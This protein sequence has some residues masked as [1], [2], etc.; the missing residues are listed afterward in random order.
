[1]GW[2]RFNRGTNVFEVSDDNG[3][4]WQ[5]LVIAAGGL[6]LGG[7]LAYTDRLNTFTAGQDFISDSGTNYDGANIELRSATPRISFHV[8][9]VIASQLG[10]ETDGSI[11]ARD[12]QAQD[13]RH[14]KRLLLQRRL[15]SGW[16]ISLRME[17]TYILVVLM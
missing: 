17:V 14:L 6:A 4:S 5:T 7:N 1:M 11:V 8:P 10:V 3:A 15:A 13:M 2:Q 12:N 16:A 9:G